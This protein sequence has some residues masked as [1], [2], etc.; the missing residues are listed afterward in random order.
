MREAVVGLE[1]M[2]PLIQE[3]LENGGTVSFTPRGISMRPMLEGGRDQVILAP[4]PGQLKKYDLPLYRRDNGQFVLHRIVRAGETYTC[5]GDNQFALESHVRQ[6]QLL[7]V[8][9]GFVRKGK[10][11][12]VNQLSYR[13]YCRFWHWSRP[14]RYLYRRGIGFLRRRIAAR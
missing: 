14:M 7:A 9:T 3:Q 4:L 12:T 11:Y 8:V 10:T 5:V 13:L 2:M 6:D 1:Q